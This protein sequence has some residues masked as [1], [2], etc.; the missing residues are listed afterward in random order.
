VFTACS[1]PAAGPFSQSPSAVQH[2]SI[3]L[4]GQE[5]TY[6]LFRPPSL[7]PKRPVPLVVALAG[8]PTTG[9][10][11][12]AITH[13]DDQATTGGFVVVYPDPVG[14]CWNTGI[15]CCSGSGDDV[16]FI[17]RLLDRLST[18]IRIDKSR[19]FAAGA[20]AGG[21]MAYR[22]ACELSDRF[23]AI[24]SVAGLMGPQACRPKRPVSILEMHGTNDSVVPYT[25][26]AEA[27]QQW[28]TLDGCVGE[29]TR[30]VSGITKTSTWSNCQGSTVIRF[31]TVE[32]GHHSWFGSALDPVPREPNSNATVWGFFTHLGARG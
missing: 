32:G 22:V 13:L 4:D 3:R 1:G 23:T 8:C 6:R 10:D 17:N 31:D 15:P 21:I 24:A 12:A 29:P 25:G 18:D 16:T 7:D 14:G 30:S 9:D 20:S 5:R 11:M 27:V 28:V 2:A 19:T 26:G